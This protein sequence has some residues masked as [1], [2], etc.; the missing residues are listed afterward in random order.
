[1]TYKEDRMRKATGISTA[2]LALALALTAEGARVGMLDAD[3]YGPS[4]QMMMGLSGR[5]ESTDGKTIEP[6]ENHGVQSMSIGVLTDVDQ[7]M[8]WRG[9]MVT[10]ALEQ[11][12][13]DTQWK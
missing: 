6:M 3:I 10:Q 13:R 7:P 2:A 8:V 1:M 5:P 11:L 12:L 4:Q 9:P